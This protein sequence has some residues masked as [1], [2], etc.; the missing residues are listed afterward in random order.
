[1]VSSKMYYHRSK[2]LYQLSSSDE[3]WFCEKCD[4]PFNFTDSFFETS[5]STLKVSLPASFVP[6]DSLPHSSNGFINRLLLNVMS[7]RHKINDF[8]ALLLMD[9]LDIVAMTET[10][11]N[12]DFSDSELQVD[13][14][15]IFCFDRVNRQ[16]GGV[17][18]ALNSCLSCSH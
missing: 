9:S 3:Q 14:Y 1:M 4:W 16:G 8:L 6:V 7:L 5:F 10:W 2:D 11:L 12:N 18:L 17:L 15:N 13:G